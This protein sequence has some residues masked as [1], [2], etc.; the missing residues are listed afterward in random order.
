MRILSFNIWGDYGHFKKFHTTSSPL[1]FSLP[2]P[3]AIYG[4]IG[5]IKGLPKSDYITIL[6]GYNVKVAIGLNNPI[7]KMRMG[8][9]WI[10]LKKSF[11]KLERAPQIK[12]EFLCDCSFKIYIT[13]KEEFLDELRDFLINHRSYYTPCMGISQCLANFN[14]TG[15]Y[16]GM[17]KKISDGEEVHVITTIPSSYPLKIEPGKSYHKERMPVL[18]NPDRQVI[19]YRDIIFENNGKPLC[20]E[21]GEYIDL[22]TEKAIVFLNS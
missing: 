12:Q 2:P 18:M 11:D 19:D 21:G 9:N 22:G 5:A 17:V 20:I 4:I 10:E 8:V 7:K 13:G 6:T 3:T 16:P 14:F 1:S 15:E